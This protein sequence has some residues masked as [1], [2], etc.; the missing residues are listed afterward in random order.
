ME[1]LGWILLVLLGFGIL[2]FITV[3]LAALVAFMGPPD[4]N[5]VEITD[6]KS[7]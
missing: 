7:K 6:Q 5:D 3:G 4:I 2:S 1:A